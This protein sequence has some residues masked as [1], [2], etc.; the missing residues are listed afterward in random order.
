MQKSSETKG[1]EPP[2]TTRIGTPQS[3][4]D[5]DPTFLPVGSNYP[6]YYIPVTLSNTQTTATSPNYQVQ[7]IINSNNN[8]LLYA[9]NLSNV[10]WQDGVGTG[11]ILKSWLESGATNTSTSTTYWVNLGQ[12]TIDHQSQ[13]TIYEMVYA[14]NVM[15]MN[16]GNTGAYP[17]YSGITTGTYGL[18]D[19]GWAVFQ[20]FY[21]NFAGGAL[22][23][24]L[25]T[26][27]NGGATVSNGLTFASSATDLYLQSVAATYSPIVTSFDANW[28]VVY[29]NNAGHYLDFGYNSRD[30]PTNYLQWRGV[31]GATQAITRIASVSTTFA[32][33]TTLN[34]YQ[35]FSVWSNTTSA[36]AIAVYANNNASST[37]NVD[38]TSVR[39][40]IENN[41]GGATLQTLNVGWVRLRLTAPNSVSPSVSV[42][43]LTTLKPSVSIAPQYAVIDQGNSS[44]ISYTVLSGGFNPYSFQWFAKGPSAS[45]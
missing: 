32:T 11:T 26:A 40:Y 25:W 28:S 7:I 18:Y 24:T 30:G 35:I 9:T 14:T 4:D 42:G 41:G 15:A 1:Q 23:A 6:I 44:S 31:G 29:P 20:S 12:D 22:N 13:L 16:N 37:T 10:N 3:A 43:A 45:S 34:G 21:D 39:L 38:T 5:G 2:I 8:A 19:D 17:S 33:Q 36:N 27:P